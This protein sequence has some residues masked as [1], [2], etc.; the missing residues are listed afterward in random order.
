M[1][2]REMAPRHD[3]RN[4]QHDTVKT[5]VVGK[6]QLQGRQKWMARHGAEET[7]NHMLLKNFILS[8]SCL[9]AM[10]RDGIG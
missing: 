1:G 2:L 6:A 7:N 3:G 9:I 5:Q 10:A 4:G 8:C